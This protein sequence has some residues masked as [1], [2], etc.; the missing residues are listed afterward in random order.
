MFTSDDYTTAMNVLQDI[1]GEFNVQ[2]S[3]LT[4]DP[5]EGVLSVFK[6]PPGLAKMKY[7]SADFESF[8][9]EHGLYGVMSFEQDNG[10]WVI[11]SMCKLDSTSNDTGKEKA[12]TELRRMVS[13]S[14]HKIPIRHMSPE[15]YILINNRSNGQSDL[16]YYKSDINGRL[17]CLFGR[18]FNGTIKAE[19]GTDGFIRK[20]QVVEGENKGAYVKFASQVFSDESQVEFYTS[21]G[22]CENT[23]TVQGCFDLRI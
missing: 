16:F 13:L 22:R 12:N 19:V 4:F 3:D 15:K 14:Q 7:S 2:F 5:N 1:C 17:S 8:C 21:E 23:W 11:F 6:R 18:K 20:L 9:K 10:A